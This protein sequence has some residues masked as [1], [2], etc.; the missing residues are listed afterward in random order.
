MKM[1]FDT[2][3]TGLIPKGANWETDYNL[4][5]YIVQIAWIMNDK[6]NEYIIKPENWEIPEDVIRVH[7]SDNFKAMTEGQSN[8]EVL[9]LLLE[10]LLS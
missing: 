8:L 4:F 6:E 9:T 3:T 2:E 5:P 7:G 10:D 1:Y